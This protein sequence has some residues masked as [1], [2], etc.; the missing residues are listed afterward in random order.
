[1]SLQMPSPDVSKHACVYN[2]GTIKLCK[3]LHGPLSSGSLHP[4]D[5]H[6]KMCFLGLWVPTPVRLQAT[7]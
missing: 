1:M 4:Y 3:K 2:F 6:S 7:V 5:K